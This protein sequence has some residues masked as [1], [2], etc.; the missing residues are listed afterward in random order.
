[1]L[2][3]CSCNPYL[4]YNT[5]TSYNLVITHRLTR[6]CLLFTVKA[7]RHHVGGVDY[8]ENLMR[9]GNFVSCFILCFFSPTTTL[10]S[11]PQVLFFH[12]NDIWL[13]LGFGE[14]SQDAHEPQR[15]LAGDPKRKTEGNKVN[16]CPVFLALQQQLNALQRGDIICY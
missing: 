15:D 3:L 16:I 4:C 9:C 2:I 7:K 10:T 11:T 13:F 6:H 8:S 5:C 12:D 1:M 14:I